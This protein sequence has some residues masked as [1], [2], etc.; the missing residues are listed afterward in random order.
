MDMPKPQGTAC[1]VTQCSTGQCDAVGKCLITPIN[2]GAPCDDNAFCTTGEACNNL[3]QCTGG[4]PTC[5]ATPQQSCVDIG[6]DEASNSCTQA[7]LPDGMACDD[8]NGCTLGT[9]CTAGQCKAM[10]TITSCISN[11]GCCP[12]GCTLANDSDCLLY[13]PGVQQN[14]AESALAG[15]SVCYSGNYGD[16]V[17]LMT[18][19]ANC[20]KAKLLMACRPT[21]QPTFNLV[22]MA[23][24]VDVL[25]D[26]GQQTNCTKQ[27]NGVGWYYSDS[28]SWGF[29]QGGE[30]VY[31]NSC[32]YGGGG[33]QTNPHLRMCWHTGGGSTNG[34]YRCGDDNLGPYPD[35]NWQRVV[36]HAN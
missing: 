1:G 10:S 25:F 23:P 31:R 11:D 12:A 20:N 9:T 8:G 14:V 28:F 6:C 2:V 27:S 26:C 15:W 16:N 18:I 17:S 19:L 5:Q 21:G 36:Y 30:S 4:Q 32:D 13:V 3:G 24:R 7:L 22:A 33:P 29:A 34:G 35:Q